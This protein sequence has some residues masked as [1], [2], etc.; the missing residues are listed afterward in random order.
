MWNVYSFEQNNIKATILNAIGKDDLRL[1]MQYLKQN[2][3]I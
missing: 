1:K 3:I 2:A